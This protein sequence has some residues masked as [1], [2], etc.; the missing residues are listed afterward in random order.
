MLAAAIRNRFGSVWRS[1]SQP[2]CADNGARG[3]CEADAI[4]LSEALRAVL[5]EWLTAPVKFDNSILVALGEMGDSAAVAARWGGDL[6]RFYED[7][8]HARAPFRNWIIRYA[9][10]LRP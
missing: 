3:K 6:R 7:A 9:Q 10:R 5:S 1:P 2:P 4:E 8:Y